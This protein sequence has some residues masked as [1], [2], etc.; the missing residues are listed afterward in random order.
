VKR[1]KDR[2]YE[3]GEGNKKGMMNEHVKEIIVL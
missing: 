2:R 3:R 1:W